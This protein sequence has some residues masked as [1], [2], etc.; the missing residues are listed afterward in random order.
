[1]VKK[2]KV[3]DLVVPEIIETIPE[4][5]PEIIEISDLEIITLENNDV[6]IIKD[7]ITIE[8]KKDIELIKDIDLKTKTKTYN[9]IACPNCNK[10][11]SSATLKY[12]HKKFCNPDKIPKPKTKKS[13]TEEIVKMKS[14][15][16]KINKALVVKEKDETYIKSQIITEIPE[17]EEIKKRVIK[18]TVK[19]TATNNTPLVVEKKIKPDIRQ[20]KTDALKNLIRNAF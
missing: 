17:E 5:T 7:D 11:M 3:I 12:S 13:N 9:Q 15:L 18:N 8:D 6:D 1:M 20:M 14:D 4:I 16:S 10:F 2:I 19:F